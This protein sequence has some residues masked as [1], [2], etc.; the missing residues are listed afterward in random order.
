[1]SL[2]IRPPAHSRIRLLFLLCLAAFVL[3]HPG[4]AYA[5]SCSANTTS[6]AFG[7]VDVV[8]NS[9]NYSSSYNSTAANI[10]V[11]CSVLTLVGTNKFSVCVN[12]AGAAGGTSRTM[13]GP[14]GSSLPTI[15]PVT[16]TSSGGNKP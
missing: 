8:A 11:T 5:Q 13:A 2:L 16:C 10:S 9:Q 3:L 14:S 15:G 6:V 1:M 7:P 12:I 4:K